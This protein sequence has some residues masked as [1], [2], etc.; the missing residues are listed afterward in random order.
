MH[1]KSLQQKDAFQINS[2]H[3]EAKFRIQNEATKTKIENERTEYIN[4]KYA[5][6]CTLIP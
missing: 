3:K 6:R 4:S 1:S 5:K 2:K